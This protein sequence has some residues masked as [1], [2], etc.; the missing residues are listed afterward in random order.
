[1][2]QASDSVEEMKL[3]NDGMSEPA[4]GQLSG[5]FRRFR[6]QLSPGNAQ[7]SLSATWG[8]AQEPLLQ[9]VRAFFRAE[10]TKDSHSLAAS[11]IEDIRHYDIAG[12]ERVAAICR[13]GSSGS[14][15]L[16]SYL[17][18]HD[19]VITL[20][21]NL[22][23]AIY[24]FFDYYQSLSLHDK[25]LAY[26][27]VS[28]DGYDHSQ[29]FF[30]GEH[31][32]AAADYYA[33]VKALFEVHGNRPREFLESRRAF[34][35]FLHIVYNVALGRRP[36]S[37]HPLIVYAQ[38]LANDHLARYL[39]EDFPQA[40]FIHTVRDPISNCGRLFEHDLKPHGS[41]A[42]VY[43][44]AR[45]VIWDKPHSGMASRTRAIRF[46]DLHLHLEETMAA[47]AAWLGIPYQPSLLESTINGHEFVWRPRTGTAWSGVRPQKAVRDSRNV[48]FT[49][50][51]L[52]FAVLHEDF[53]AWDYTEPK[54][55]RHALVR[56][57]TCMLV[58]LIPMKI[59]IITARMVL[60]LLPSRRFGYAIKG[61]L[62]VCI[63]RVAI[64]SLLAVDLY[65]R[66]VVGKQ[67]LELL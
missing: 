44:I 18:G 35:Q 33:A 62:R 15:L 64:M 28:I 16:A 42:A 3:P 34:F 4:A 29:Y 13:W 12:M 25:L 2:R 19:D 51:G 65:R 59:E 1:M 32:V 55:F 43:V 6:R 5:A 23:G 30:Q 10:E 8:Q 61:L 47:V 31:G 58:L 27:F 46:E 66:L 53:V 67:V 48:S 56:V 39:V 21:G 11:K 36:V 57:L 50:R 45:L 24:P 37:P 7:S 22:S 14:L 38:A 60:K 52:L 9:R 26:P 41:L 20:P 17:D 40:R 63:G 54:I 49:D